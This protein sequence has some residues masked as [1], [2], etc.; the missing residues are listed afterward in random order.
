MLLHVDDAPADLRRSVLLDETNLGADKER[1][2]GYASWLCLPGWTWC[3]LRPPPLPRGQSL[4]AI[5][6]LGRT[7]CHTAGA[8]C[9]HIRH[10]WRAN[11]KTPRG[12]TQRGG[13]F[14]RVMWAS[15]IAAAKEIKQGRFDVL[16]AGTSGSDL[17]EMFRQFAITDAP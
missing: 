1:H 10:R 9:L 3:W 5:V 8:I 7:T 12:G 14:A 16:E 6:A 4:H 11:E 13:A 17:N 2:A 15:A